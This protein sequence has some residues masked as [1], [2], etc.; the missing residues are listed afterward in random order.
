VEGFAGQTTV[1]SP[2]PWSI[3]AIANTTPTCC[4]TEGYQDKHPAVS[5]VSPA[6]P[7]ELL[8]GHRAYWIPTCVSAWC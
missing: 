1:G 8:P 3:T 6:S 2:R 7:S 4:G 5:Y